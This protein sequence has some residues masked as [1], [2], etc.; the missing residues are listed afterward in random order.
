MKVNNMDAE[1]T[2]QLIAKL[3]AM[4]Q[5]LMSMEGDLDEVKDHIQDILDNLAPDEEDDPLFTHLSLLNDTTDSIGSA[6]SALD[7]ILINLGAR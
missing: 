3:E 6:M 4:D 2:K 5:Q 1:Y 7:G